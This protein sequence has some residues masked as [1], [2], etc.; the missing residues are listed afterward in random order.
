MEDQKNQIK[1]MMKSPIFAKG[2]MMS[3]E[4]LDPDQKKKNEQI[5]DEISKNREEILELINRLQYDNKSKTGM[6]EVQKI[7]GL[8]L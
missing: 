5:R 7:K 4:S 2:S 3:L 1:N 6:A 8:Y